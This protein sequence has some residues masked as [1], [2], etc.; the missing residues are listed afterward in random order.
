V[1]GSAIDGI[2]VASG[3]YNVLIDRVS[4]AGSSDGNIDIT[5]SRDVTVAWSIIGNNKKSML[6]KYRST[7][8]TLHHNILVGSLERSPQ[9]RVDDTE[10]AAATETTADLRNNLVANW[11]T[12]YG[13]IIW[14]GP[15]VNVVNNVYS[16]GK[17]RSALE[18]KSAR[19]FA[20][21]N[22]STGEFD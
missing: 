8:V 21:G 11:H 6:I 18:V 16:S 7:R 4:V 9:V 22:L 17:H 13:T 12:G 19:V 14:Y 1:R 5:E 15:W 3:A 10:T 20:A 2:Q